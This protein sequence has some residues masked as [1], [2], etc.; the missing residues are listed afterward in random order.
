MGTKKNTKK[1]TGRKSEKEKEFI[2]PPVHNEH[3]NI[4]FTIL[5][6]R[7]VTVRDSEFET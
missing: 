5:I 7:M 2:L 1:T 4:K 6:T 3:E